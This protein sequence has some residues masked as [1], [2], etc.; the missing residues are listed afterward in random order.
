MQ[1]DR[2]QG[3]IDCCNYVLSLIDDYSNMGREV[4]LIFL[5][6]QLKDKLKEKDEEIGEILDKMYEDYKKNNK[7]NGKNN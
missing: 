6:E 4:F 3:Y 7:I 2:N 1:I 5:K